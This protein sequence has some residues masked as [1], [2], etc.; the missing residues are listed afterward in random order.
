MSP[1]ARFKDVDHF[2]YRTYDAWG[3]L[4]YVGCSKDV[5]KRLK[6]HPKRGWRKRMCR[7]EVDGPYSYPVARS[8]ERELIC[9]ANPQHNGDTPRAIAGRRARAT[10]FESVMRA[11]LASGEDL[12]TAADQAAVATSFE[13]PDWLRYELEEVVA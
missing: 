7:C 6:E 13:F 2:V 5:E 10:F 8:I 11:A 3:D 9:T 1:A 12:N 4:L